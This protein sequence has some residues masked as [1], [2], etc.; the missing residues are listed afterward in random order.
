MTN[1]FKWAAIIPAIMAVLTILFYS[2]SFAIRM[3][4]NISTLQLKHVEDNLI[5]VDKSAFTEV[6]I[7]L[8]NISKNLIELKKDL[9]EDMA[10][11][12]SRLKRV[13]DYLINGNKY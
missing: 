12:R 5:F 9:K 8:A 13:E 2:V 4:Q 7:N 10:E 3:D 11:N 6:K 1:L